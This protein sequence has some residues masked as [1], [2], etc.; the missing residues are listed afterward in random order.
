MKNNI[1]LN[2]G[3]KT[4]ISAQE[5]R[6]MI[7]GNKT[8]AKKEKAKF[9]PL[10]CEIDGIKINVKPL[11]V[12]QAWKGQRFKT[13]A[14]KD[15]ERLLFRLLPPI[16]LPTPPFQVIFRFGFSST[17]SDWDNPIKPLQDILQKKYGFDDKKIKRAVVDIESV[18]KGS[19]YVFFKIE[20]L[21]K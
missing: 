13:D 8:P 1:K 11:S 2:I 21:N 14:Y 18:E 5:F 6:E 4:A 7:N 16:D 3:E 10:K 12:N 17:L 9:E 19:E 20:K 15:Y